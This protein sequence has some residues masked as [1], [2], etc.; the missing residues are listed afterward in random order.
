MMTTL[1]S[2]FLMA[3]IELSPCIH[4]CSIREKTVEIFQELLKQENI[5]LYLDKLI[6]PS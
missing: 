1:L 5:L 2:L 4:K 3:W 6:Y